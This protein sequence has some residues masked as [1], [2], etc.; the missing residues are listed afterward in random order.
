MVLRGNSPFAAACLVCSWPRCEHSHLS[1]GAGQLHPAA[2]HP[3][4]GEQTKYAQEW[5]LD[6]VCEVAFNWRRRSMVYKPGTGSIYISTYK[7]EAFPCVT[8]ALFQSTL[9]VSQAA[10][11]C[12][13]QNPIHTQTNNK[14]Q[15]Q[16]QQ[17]HQQTSKQTN[18]QDNPQQK[19]RLNRLRDAPL[20][21][22]RFC[23]PL[24]MVE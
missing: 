2:E 8:S 24:A 3:F 6:R 23:R 22:I 11:R 14:Q 17:Q 4:A 18:R 16:Q 12:Q 10:K 13:K 15:H 1:S 5:A 19:R 21:H 7:R 20:S 9:C